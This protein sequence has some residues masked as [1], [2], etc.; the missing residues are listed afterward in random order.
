[1][2][3]L[4]LGAALAASISPALAD[5]KPSMSATEFKAVVKRALKNPYSVRDFSMSP[6]PYVIGPDAHGVKHWIMCANYFAANSYGGL[7]RGG[8]TVFFKDGLVADIQ[9]TQGQGCARARPA[10]F[11]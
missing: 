5:T 8:V 9:P 10:S 2:K 7:V 4:L 6:E 11:D 1:M 3:T